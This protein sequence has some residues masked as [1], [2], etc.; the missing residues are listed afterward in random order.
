MA[1]RTD[2]DGDMVGRVGT[3]G[4]SPEGVYFS[5][6]RKATSGEEEVEGCR[7]RKI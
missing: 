1:P 7:E 4:L 2:T 6:A 3:A 5:K